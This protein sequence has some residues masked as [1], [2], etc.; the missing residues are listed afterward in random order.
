[1]LYTPHLFEPSSRYK[2]LALSLSFF[3]HV[4]TILP[5]FLDIQCRLKPVLL[6]NQYRK[7]ITIPGSLGTGFSSRDDARLRPAPS[8]VMAKAHS[9]LFPRPH[10]HS[11]HVDHYQP[12][13][14]SRRSMTPA[15][16]RQFVASATASAKSQSWIPMQNENTLRWTI[17]TTNPP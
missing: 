12:R 1:M 7:S 13:S 4:W 15:G 2:S 11:R 9:L 14:T 8:G 3:R 5:L 16:F 6:R 10:T 17:S